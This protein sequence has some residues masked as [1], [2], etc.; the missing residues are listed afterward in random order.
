MNPIGVFFGWPLGGV[1]SNLVAS[2]IWATPAGIAT[3]RK[4]RR[5][6]AERMGQ[7][8]RHHAEVQAQM[9]AQHNT[10]LHQ[11]EKHHQ[12]ALDLAQANHEAL[13]DHLT[14]TLRLPA[15]QPRAPKTPAK[16]AASEGH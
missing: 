13:R 1:W 5:Q 11:A 15:K 10:R 6:H 2:L 8:E 3:W 14:A 7:A 9:T 12:Q 16:E 4:L